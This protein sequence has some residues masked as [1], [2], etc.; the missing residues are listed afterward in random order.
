MKRLTEVE[1]ATKDFSF[2]GVVTDNGQEIAEGKIN[3]LTLT[4]FD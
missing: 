4:K 2:A 3:P 1:D